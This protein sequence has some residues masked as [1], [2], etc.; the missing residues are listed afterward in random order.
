[1]DEYLHFLVFH[2]SVESEAAE[3][4]GLAFEVFTRF[5][6]G[7]GDERHTGGCPNVP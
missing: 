3:F 6:E 7:G 1:M 4:G 2:E 5:S